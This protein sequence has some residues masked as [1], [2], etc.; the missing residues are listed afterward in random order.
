[1]K[2]KNQTVGERCSRGTNQ[3]EIKHIYIFSNLYIHTY[4]HKQNVLIELM[5]AY[6]YKLLKIRNNYMFHPNLL[7]KMKMPVTPVK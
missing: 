5:I 4:S 1:M 6:N 3:T 2:E 7:D